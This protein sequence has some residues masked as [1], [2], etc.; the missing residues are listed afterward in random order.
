MNT[1]GLRTTGI[2]TGN[3]GKSKV[4]G[5]P[6]ELDLSPEILNKENLRIPNKEEAYARLAK[7]YEATTDPQLKEYLREMLKRR[8]AT[9]TPGKPP[10][11]QKEETHW[12]IVKRTR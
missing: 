6:G 12:D 2:H 9:T 8:I 4:K 7:A 10:K 1:H 5:K 11:T 3:F